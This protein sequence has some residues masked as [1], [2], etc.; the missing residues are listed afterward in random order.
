[1]KHKQCLDT[2]ITTTVEIYIN[3][4]TT[5]GILASFEIGGTATALSSME[6]TIV[7]QF[8]HRFYEIFLN[9]SRMFRSEMTALYIS[10]T[11]DASR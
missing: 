3:Q 9:N 7:A 8:L 10:L 6:L 5:Y 4:S 2:P 11:Y 1:M